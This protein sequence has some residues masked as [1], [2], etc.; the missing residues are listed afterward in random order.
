MV[1]RGLPGKIISD[2]GT[3][4]KAAVKAIRALVNHPDVQGYLAGLGVKWIFHGLKAPWWKGVFERVVKS[5]KRCLRKIIGQ[6]KSSHDELL[7]AITE[8]EIVLN[9]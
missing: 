9:S 1:R 7:T 3:T 2:N 5:T 4:F 8:V 6:A